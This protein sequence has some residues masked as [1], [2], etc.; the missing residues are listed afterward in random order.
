M[1]EFDDGVRLL[2]P[3][4]PVGPTTSDTVSHIR[5]SKDGLLIKGIK[6]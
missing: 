4:F 1:R 2:L 6:N 5:T 3:T